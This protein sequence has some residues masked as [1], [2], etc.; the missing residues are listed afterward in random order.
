MACNQSGVVFFP[1]RDA[2]IVER[3]AS[4]GNERGEDGSGEAAATMIDHA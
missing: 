3:D 4:V 1:Y 2:H